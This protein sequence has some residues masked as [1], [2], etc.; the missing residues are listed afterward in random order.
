MSEDEFL[1]ALISVLRFHEWVGFDYLTTVYNHVNYQA[2]FNKLIIRISNATREPVSAVVLMSGLLD[3]SH[4]GIQRGFV[5][6]VQ[7][8]KLQ[9][10]H[11][12]MWDRQLGDFLQANFHHGENELDISAPRWGER[13]ERIRQMVAEVLDSGIE[14]KDAEVAAHEQFKLYSIEFQ[15]VIAALRRN[16]WHQL[17]FEGS[18]RRRLNTART[19]AS[20]REE[21]R[22]Y[23]TRAG[24]VM[25]QY[26][27]EAGRRFKRQGW[28]SHEDDVFMLQTEDLRKIAQKKADKAPILAISR[29]R[30]LMYRGYRSLEPPGELGI[31]ISPFTSGPAVEPS[32]AILLKGTGCSAGKIEAPARVVTTLSDCHNLNS[33]EILVARSTDPSWTPVFGLVSGI[34][35]EVGGLLSHGAVLSREYGLPAVFAVPNATHIIKTGQMLEVDGSL[36]TVRILANAGRAPIARPHETAHA[37]RGS[38]RQVTQTA[39][40]S[41]EASE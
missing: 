11:S 22:E 34:V 4:M 14:P 41:L 40:C 15:K 39:S 23:S 12:E 16:L 24:F 9:G 26:A 20:R 8:A 29:F 7:A 19:Y 35:T 31:G 28:L 1:A 32:G 5:K 27:L 30:R 25:R 6:L 3:V 36:G 38:R 17:R 33:R 13:P 2:D 18:F 21:M 10:I 37:V